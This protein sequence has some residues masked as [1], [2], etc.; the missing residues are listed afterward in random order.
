MLSTMINGPIPSL[1]KINITGICLNKDFMFMVNK[2]SLF[3]IMRFNQSAVIIM[4]H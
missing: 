2:H 3:K 4:F 1:D